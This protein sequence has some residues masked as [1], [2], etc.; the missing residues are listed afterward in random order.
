MDRWLTVLAAEGAEVVTGAPCAEG[1][2]VRRARL[3]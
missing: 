3:A 1:E 2:G